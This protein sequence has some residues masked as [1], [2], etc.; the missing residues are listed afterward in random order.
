MAIDPANVPILGNPNPEVPP[1]AARASCSLLLLATVGSAAQLA[2]Y[3]ATADH[4]LSA[5]LIPLGLAIWFALSTRAGRSWA[6]PA[7]LATGIV[8][9]LPGAT[10]CTGATGLAVVLLVL[11]ALVC[12]GRLMF[13]TEVRAHFETHEPGTRP[14]GSP[15]G[16]RTPIR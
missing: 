5:F 9:A 14:S 8:N 3:G 7:G 2:F 4:D 1:A 6:R 11:L 16:S 13:R 10:L 15:R 12:A